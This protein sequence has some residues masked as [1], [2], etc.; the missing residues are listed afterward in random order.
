MGERMST[1]DAT[2]QCYNAIWG[3]GPQENFV[4]NNWIVCYKLHSMLSV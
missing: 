1:E 4:R 2:I 3:H